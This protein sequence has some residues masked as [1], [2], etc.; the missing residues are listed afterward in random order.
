MRQWGDRYAAP[1]GPP[2]RLTHK[3]C[4]H[5]ADAVMVCTACGKPIGPE[6][7]HAHLGPGAVEP[8]IGAPKV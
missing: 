2:L 3:G 1:D 7:V 6:N 8:L 4:G 5:V